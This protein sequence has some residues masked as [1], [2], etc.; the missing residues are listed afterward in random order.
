MTMGFQAAGMRVAETLRVLERDPTLKEPGDR[1]WA[2]FSAFGMDPIEA[3]E[4]T[5]NTMMMAHAHSL[6]RPDE[7]EGAWESALYTMLLTG[8][9]LGQASSGGGN[10]QTQPT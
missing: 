9:I 8:F 10:G 1:M 7:Q 6:A 4:F 3:V 5:T 2:M